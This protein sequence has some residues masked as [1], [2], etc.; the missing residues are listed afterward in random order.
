MVSPTL[1]SSENDQTEESNTEVVEPLT[2]E[3]ITEKSDS[4]AVIPKVP[5]KPLSGEKQTP[6]LSMPDED[7][8]EEEEV[9]D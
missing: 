1:E 9:F 7:E 5:V 2:T 6:S 8:A 3:S 4:A